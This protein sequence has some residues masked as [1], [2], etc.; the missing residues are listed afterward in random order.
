[1]KNELEQYL[2]NINKEL[3]SFAFALLPDDLQVTQIILD[4]IT[5]LLLERSELVET[6]NIC[7]TEEDKANTFLSIKMFLYRH[8]YKLIDKRAE[9]LKGSIETQSE[10]SEYNGLGLVEKAV[11]FFRSKTHLGFEDIA[12]ILGEG[13]TEIFQHLANGRQ[14]LALRAGIQMEGNL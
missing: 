6:L 14:N 12:F 1:M 5:V 13:K 4:S 7:E 3:Y 2:Q 8:I 9:Q 11:L 10:Y